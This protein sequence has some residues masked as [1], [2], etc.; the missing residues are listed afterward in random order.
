MADHE[1][2]KLV[3]EMRHWQRVYFKSKDRNKRTLG[4]C[5]DLERRVDLGLKERFPQ[6]HQL[7]TGQQ[8]L[9]E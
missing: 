1:F 6:G 3:A 8:R 2:I 9:F 5:R 4:Y 7:L